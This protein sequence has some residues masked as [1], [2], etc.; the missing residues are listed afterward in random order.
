MKKTALAILLVLLLTATA[1]VWAADPVWAGTWETNFGTMKLT[2]QDN[3]V[4]GRYDINNDNT[5]LGTLKGVVAGDTLKG[6]WS[7][8]LGEGEFAFKLKPGNRSFDGY[9]LIDSAKSE[10]SGTKKN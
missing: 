8:T 2:Q 10:W 6:T 4:E 3:V 7:D 1:P 5:Y 9:Y